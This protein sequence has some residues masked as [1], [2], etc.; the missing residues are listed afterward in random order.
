MVQSTKYESIFSLYSPSK[1]QIITTEIIISSTEKKI[2]D[3]IL[4]VI[5]EEKLDTTCRVAGGWVRDKLLGRK[6]DDI[7]IALDNIT[8]E[9]MARLINNKIN[10]D[11]DKVGI[12]KS[13]PDKSKHLETA[14]LKIEGQFV[15]FVNLRADCYSTN[16]A[17]IIGLTS[18]LEDAK[19]RD[20]TINSMFYNINSQVVEDY[21]G[22]GLSDLKKGLIRTP[23]NPIITFKDDPLRILRAVRFAT[24]FQF[25]ID[26]EIYEA[27]KLPEI[28]LAL[29]EKISNERI[30]KELSQMFAGKFPYISLRILHQMTIF[31][32]ILKLPNNLLDDNSLYTDLIVSSLGNTL[33]VDYIISNQKDF[34]VNVLFSVDSLELPEDDQTFFKDSSMYLAIVQP[35]RNINIKVKKDTISL[36]L[37]IIKFSFMLPNETIKISQ[38]ITE[39]INEFMK[40]LENCNYENLFKCKL[41]LGLFVRKVGFKYLKYFTIIAIVSQYFERTSNQA[42]LDF[43]IDE[44]KINQ[45]ID[46]LRVLLSFLKEQDLLHSDSIKPVLDGKQIA[47]LLKLKPG[48]LIG[49]LSS[50]C[51]ELQIMNPSISRED[52]LEQLKL[53]INYLN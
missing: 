4:D 37:F 42:K 47:D 19:L 34:L 36:S 6:S 20:L 30:H 7:D 22:T 51:I 40:F 27:A 33:V 13:N 18:P 50:K 52:I 35:F 41:Q 29:K 5:K 14:T 10:K 8:G 12:V 53:Q 2:F 43:E 44:V 24:K 15:D 38:L 31:E 3:L 23:I 32:D 16:S 46:N 45:I 28:K 25:E 26:P 39:H 21:L 17:L 49:V 48:K 11:I 1:L 9:K